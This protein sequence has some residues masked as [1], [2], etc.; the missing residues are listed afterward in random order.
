MFRRGNHPEF[1]V[2]YVHGG[3]DYHSSLATYVVMTGV[4]NIKEQEVTRDTLWGNQKMT[5]DRRGDGVGTQDRMDGRFGISD[6]VL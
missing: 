6:I 3:T 5:G 4:G 2:T 1:F